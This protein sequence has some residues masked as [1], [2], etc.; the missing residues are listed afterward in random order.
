[1][2]KNA[3]KLSKWSCC[4]FCW[5][6]YTNQMEKRDKMRRLYKR[7]KVDQNSEFTE[8][9]NSKMRIFVRDEDEESGS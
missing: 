5:Q 9:K 2:I 8:L 3:I 6:E 4:L 1:M 7:E